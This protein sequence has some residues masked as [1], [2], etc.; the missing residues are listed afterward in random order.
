M[1][2]QTVRCGACGELVPAVMAEDSDGAARARSRSPHSLA[3]VHTQRKRGF[4]TVRAVAAILE[5]LD[6]QQRMLALACVQHF[7]AEASAHAVQR[8]FSLIGRDA[9]GTP[10][11]DGSGTRRAARTDPALT[12]VGTALHDPDSLQQLRAAV[13]LVC[14]CVR[15]CVHWASRWPWSLTP[16]AVQ[17]GFDVK[18]DPFAETAGTDK[19]QPRKLC[20]ASILA[21]MLM[22][23]QHALM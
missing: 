7:T 16:L 23:A 12:A 17:E 1:G 6:E 14:G 11:Q 19:R 8:A 9:G 22:P 15:A 21:M 3:R 18:F 20:P 13:Q 5:A 2:A 4:L 10:T